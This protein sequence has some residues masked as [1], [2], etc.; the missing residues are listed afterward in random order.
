M[1]NI[2]RQIPQSVI[3]MYLITATEFFL[4]INN[5]R[6]N[7]IGISNKEI[8]I[9]ETERTISFHEKNYVVTLFKEIKLC[10]ITLLD[11]FPN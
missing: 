5:N 1:E 3:D 8:E 10:N 7:Y 6:E 2:L 4:T 11:S 9:R